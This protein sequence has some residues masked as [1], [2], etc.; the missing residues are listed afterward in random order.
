MGG[1]YFFNK[2]NAPANSGTHC[3]LDCPLESTCDYSVR[4]IHLEHPVYWGAYVWPELAYNKELDTHENRQ[5]AIMRP[6]FPHSRCV[7]KCNNNQVDRQSVVVEFADGAV[8]V[9]NLV[10]GT[11]APMRKIHII[12]TE[13]EIE[14]VFDE[15]KF[16]VRRRNL[17]PAK[18]QCSY[19][20]EVVDLD[21]LGDTT[22][23]TGDHGG[24]DLRLV[25]DFVNFVQGGPTSISCTELAD[26]ITGHKMVFAADTAMVSKQRVD[27]ATFCAEKEQR[28]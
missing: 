27:F 15:N 13:G 25:A 28:Y 5:K 1:L 23:A 20:E 19:T 26:S 21:N 16:I 8:A 7:W 12:G 10:T 18:A 11:A 17:D 22:G 14:G 6:D 2:E 3:M 24:G 9:H 4:R